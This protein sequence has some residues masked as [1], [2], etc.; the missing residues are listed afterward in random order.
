MHIIWKQK[1]QNYVTEIASIQTLQ[2][3]FV[4]LKKSHLDGGILTAEFS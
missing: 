2:R 1:W 4:F 3:L